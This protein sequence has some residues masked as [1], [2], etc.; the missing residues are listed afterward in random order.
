MDAREQNGF[1]GGRIIKRTSITTFQLFGVATIRNNCF[2]VVLAVP[3]YEQLFH[4][5]SVSTRSLQSLFVLD[6]SCPAFYGA[7]NLSL[8]ALRNH[9]GIDVTV[10]SH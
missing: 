10:S 2:G 7:R 1:M 8:L 6:A 5:Y 3:A 9:L 4:R